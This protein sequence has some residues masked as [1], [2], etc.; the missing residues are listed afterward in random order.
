MRFGFVPLDVTRSCDGREQRSTALVSL[1]FLF[2]AARELRNTGFSVYAPSGVL[3]RWDRSEA[4][5][6]KTPAGRTGQRPVS[7]YLLKVFASE[8]KAELF[9]Q[10]ELKEEEW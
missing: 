3:L 4:G 5:A 7:R 6:G 1:R 9:S 2:Y 10:N 8:N